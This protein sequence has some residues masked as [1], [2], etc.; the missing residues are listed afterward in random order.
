M[1]LAKEKIILS[2]LTDFS[3]IA[4]H[5]KERMG[6]KIKGPKHPDLLCLELK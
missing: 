1:T 5:V 2:V 6:I 4:N 3:P